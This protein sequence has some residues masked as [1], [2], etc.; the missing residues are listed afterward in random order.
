M[1]VCLYESLSC[2]L[3]ARCDMNVCRFVLCINHTLYN[4]MLH[5]CTYVCTHTHTHPHT[6]PHTPTHI[7]THAHTSPTPTHTLP[8][9]THTMHTYTATPPTLLLSSIHPTNHCAPFHSYLPLIH[10]PTHRT[11]ASLLLCQWTESVCP[12]PCVPTCD[13]CCLRYTD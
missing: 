4:L 12:M 13:T 8:P 11:A 7:H 5:I 6:H 3:L 9:H 10:P 1:Y 2:L